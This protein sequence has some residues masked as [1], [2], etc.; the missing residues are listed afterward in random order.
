MLVSGCVNDGCHQSLSHLM[1]MLWDTLHQDFL[2]NIVAELVVDQVGSFGEYF[3]EQ[4]SCCFSTPAARVAVCN[5]AQANAAAKTMPGNPH[6]LASKFPWNEAGMVR[7]HHFHNLLDHIVGMRMLNGSM[8]MPLQA[9]EK[10]LEVI[11]CFLHS[12]F[13][14]RALSLLQGPNS[15]LDSLLHHCTGLWV[16][17][18]HGPDLT[19]AS[20]GVGAC[21]VVNHLPC[22]LV[23]DLWRTATSLASQPGLAVLANIPAVIVCNS[24]ARYLAACIALRYRLGHLIRRHRRISLLLIHRGRLHLH[25]HWCLY[26]RDENVPGHNC[27]LLLT[28][29]NHGLLVVFCR[30]KTLISKGRSICIHRSANNVRIRLIGGLHL[31]IITIL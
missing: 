4:R 2:D 3:L 16:F 22:P 29:G 21:R 30:C 11:V 14:V 20:F 6:A 8:D 28:G 25:G 7:W 13:I 15:H 12:I 1:L 26:Y 24:V 19:S 17:A 18:G 10:C 5:Q 31:S 27:A 23:R 9:I